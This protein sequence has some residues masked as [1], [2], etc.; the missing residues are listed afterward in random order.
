MR[1]GRGSGS[2]SGS[3]DGVAGG[4][5]DSGRLPWRSHADD[6]GALVNN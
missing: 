2:G 3:N 1:C 5:R 6:T 4:G